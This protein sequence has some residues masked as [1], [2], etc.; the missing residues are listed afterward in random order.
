MTEEKLIY[1]EPKLIQKLFGYLPNES[2]LIMAETE[3]QIQLWLKERQSFLCVALAWI[4]EQNFQGDWLQPCVK[5]GLIT[6]ETY[7]LAWLLVARYQ[8]IW[9]LVRTSYPFI[10]KEFEQAEQK[11]PFGC[12]YDLYSHIIKAETDYRMELDHL[13]YAEFS[14]PKYT[15]AM[16]WLA[17]EFSGKKPLTN[18]RRQN[19]KNLNPRTGKSV[20]SANWIH[21]VLAVAYKRANKRNRLLKYALEDYNTNM[22]RICH[23]MAIILKNKRSVAI[24]HGKLIGGSKDGTYSPKP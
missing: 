13:P 4:S 17:D 6:E 16:R 1:L 18:I 10:K 7:S 23:E 3:D 15:K 24:K 22:S 9:A 21:L 14:A 11:L 5:A 12:A 2:F 20:D 8:R 19:L